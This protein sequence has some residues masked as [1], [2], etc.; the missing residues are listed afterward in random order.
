MET[1][2]NLIKEKLHKKTELLKDT[3]REDYAQILWYRNA[4]SWAIETLE[5]NQENND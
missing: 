3:S 1:K 5:N 2:I 4:L